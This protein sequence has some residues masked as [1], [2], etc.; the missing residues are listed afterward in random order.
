[1]SEKITK[2]ILYVTSLLDKKALGNVGRHPLFLNHFFQSAPEGYRYR[3]AMHQVKWSLNRRVLEFNRFIFGGDTKSDSF[4]PELY[5]SVI[6]LFLFCMKNGINF[7]TFKGFIRSRNE[8][9][10]LFD[11]P[12]SD[13]L[14]L[15]STFPF[16]LPDMDRK[17]IIEIEDSTTLFFPF[18]RNGETLDVDLQRMPVFKIFRHLFES[19][20]CKQIL[21]HMKS[22]ADSLPL[23]FNSETIKNKVSY[24]PVGI[25]LLDNNPVRPPTNRIN[26]LFSNSWNQDIAGFFLRGGL[27]VVKA[28]RKI[29][30]KYPNVTLILRS[31]FPDKGDLNH[32]NTR[33]IIELKNELKELILKKRVLI[34]DEKMNSSEWDEIRRQSHIYMIPA[35]RIHVASTLEAMSFGMVVICSDGWGFEE[36]IEDGV[37]GLV[38]RGRH[39]KTSWIDPENGILREDYSSMF[40]ESPEVVD[41]IVEKIDFLVNHPEQ[42]LKLRQQAKEFVEKKYT[43]SRWN[44][45][46]KIVLDNINSGI[47][48]A[49]PASKQSK[50]RDKHQEPSIGIP[51]FF[52][53]KV[54]DKDETGKYIVQSSEDYHTENG[55]VL[56]SSYGYSECLS[57]IQ[58]GLE[59]S[60]PNFLSIKILKYIFAISKKYYKFIK[61]IVTIIIKY[62]TREKNTIIYYAGR[63]CPFVETKVGSHPVFNFIFHP[64][65]GYEF[66]YHNESGNYLIVNIYRIVFVRIQIIILSVKALLR[67]IPVSFIKSFFASRIIDHQK[68]LPTGSDVLVLYPTYPFMCGQHSWFIEIE[69]ML[70]LMVPFAFNGNPNPGLTRESPIIRMLE[71]MFESKRFKGVICHLLS[72]SEGLRKIFSNNPKVA[73]KIFHIPL[74]IPVPPPVIRM[75]PKSL[76]KKKPIKILFLNGWAQ[77]P[78]A[79]FRRGGLDAIESFSI[80]SETCDNVTLVFRSNLPLLNKKYINLINEGKK[81]GTIQHINGK[82]PKEELQ[83]IYQDCD[84]L[85]FPASRIA[86]TTLLQGMANSLA[87]VAS[88]GFGIEEYIEDGV[89]GLIARGFYGKTG[90]IDEEGIFREN[91]IPSLAGN[92]EVVDNSVRLMKLLIEDENYMRIIQCNA[93]KSVEKK[94][95]MDSWNTRLV[96]VLEQTGSSTK[97]VDADWG[98]RKIP[99]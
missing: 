87:V 66:R 7:E 15:F 62:F 72:T 82:I 6:K 19:P 47:K 42:F 12:K 34:Y 81:R 84:I 92:K 58:H 29:A 74:G 9:D 13:E 57:Y 8:N 69:D 79:F 44:K 23:I 39:G 88:D 35:A 96:D 10:S 32:K 18:I 73:S 75:N 70:T 86:V 71:L 36:Y 68:E 28:F 54:L 2:E 48:I 99:E 65:A 43:L 78:R 3:N 90:Y 37:T 30:K 26:I 11:L 95:S 50:G 24:I 25:T 91:Y 94:F 56:F 77:D 93:R 59:T 80:L 31:N 27:D 21:C 14:I 49:D 5:I 20:N 46:F 41:Q 4:S 33:A 16:I 40:K 89:D 60:E 53:E 97:S 55:N 67:G 17:W 38:I 98:L 1:M 76:N 85:L 22:T 45:S 51:L 52:N 64:P 63:V 61:P 83:K